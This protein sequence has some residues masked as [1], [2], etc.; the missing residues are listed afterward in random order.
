MGE[1]EPHAT[2]TSGSLSESSMRCFKRSVGNVY[3]SM[4]IVVL[5]FREVLTIPE[6]VL[7]DA[8]LQIRV[9]GW[10]VGGATEARKAM[11]EGGEE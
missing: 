5:R 4:T 1:K 10:F 2:S 9:D 7:Y 11:V 8:E 6:S 3:E